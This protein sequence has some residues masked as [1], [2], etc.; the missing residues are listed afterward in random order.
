MPL[1]RTVLLVGG[2]GRTGR[3]VLQ[4]LVSRGVLVRAIVRS[5][6][7]LP[8]GI[9]GN[10][11]VA[12][13]EASLLSLSDLELQDHL[14]GCDAVVSCLGHVLSLRGVLGPPYD[15]VTRATSRLCRALEALRPA[16]PARFILMSSVSVHRPGG[17]D[18]RRGALERAFLWM[19][20]GV[21]PPA[22]DNQRAA[23]F[24][25]ERIGPAHPFVQWAVVRPD[26]LLDGEVSEYTVHEGLVSSLFAPG[27][28]RMANVA[29]FMCE[30]VTSP[31]AWSAWQ[32]KAPVVVDAPAG[33]AVG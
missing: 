9:V 22:R 24:L 21:L 17:L 20:R 13:V 6:R 28:T 4:Q 23:D 31:E 33:R 1:Q 12:L 11:G 14:R 10:P 27:Q 8:E 18:T 5:A 7:G 29:H 19:L 3:R 16:S 32:G 2:T 30:L 25:R 15:L 26:S